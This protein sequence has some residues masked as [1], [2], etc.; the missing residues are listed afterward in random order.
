MANS[1]NKINISKAITDENPEIMQWLSPPDPRRRYH[2]VRTDRLDG[3][4]NWILETKEFQEWSGTRGGVDKA[5][6]FYYRDLG[7]RKTYLR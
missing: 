1:H 5:I 2:D 3:V 7:V 4:G 6:L